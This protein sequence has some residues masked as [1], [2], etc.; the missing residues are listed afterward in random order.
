MTWEREMSNG[1]FERQTNIAGEGMLAAKS[2]GLRYVDGRRSG[3]YRGRR[4]NG[5]SYVSVDG[6][7]LRDGK[8]LT[9]IRSLAIPPAR[10]WRDS[11]SDF[12]QL[13]FAKRLLEL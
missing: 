4:G 6:R 9:R 11:L 1:K 3:I 13:V 10:R 5:F 7:P 8:T 2:A 12:R